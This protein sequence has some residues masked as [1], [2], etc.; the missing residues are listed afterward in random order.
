MAN[1]TEALLKSC[2]QYKEFAKLDEYANLEKHVYLDY[3]G[4]GLAAKRQYEAHCARLAHT[5][6]GNPHSTSPTSKAATDLVEE[7]RK[8]ILSS[9]NASEE[10]YMVIFTANATGAARLVGEGYQF[11]RNSK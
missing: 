10:D 9:L 11:K 7:T 2:P 1:D 4:A 8:R 6:F 3:A 5:A